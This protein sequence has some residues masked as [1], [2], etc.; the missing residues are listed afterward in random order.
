MAR[1][2]YLS[3]RCLI[4]GLRIFR[5]ERTQRRSLRNRFFLC[6]L[7]DPLWL[8]YFNNIWCRLG[9][10]FQADSAFAFDGRIPTALRDLLFT[11]ADLEIYN[12]TGRPISMICVGNIW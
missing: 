10:N 7:C 9:L 1:M 3:F 12:C 2:S 5:R 11:E 4:S 6:A 8:D